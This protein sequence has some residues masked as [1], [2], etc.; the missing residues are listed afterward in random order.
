C[1]LFALIH[2]DVANATVD[3]TTLRLPCTASGEVAYLVVAAGE[4]RNLESGLRA[5]HAWFL[6]IALHRHPP[7]DYHCRDVAFVLDIETDILCVEIRHPSF[8][9]MIRDVV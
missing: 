4:Q 7:F 8:A 6:A 2:R 3:K 1:E 5:T 9:D